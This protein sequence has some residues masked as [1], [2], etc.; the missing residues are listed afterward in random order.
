MSQGHARISARRK[1]AR[2]AHGRR[3]FVIPNAAYTPPPTSAQARLPSL[4]PT[5]SRR[6]AAG[7]A[8]G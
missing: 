1:A 5:S 6:E 7:R 4:Q 2:N 8:A 3:N